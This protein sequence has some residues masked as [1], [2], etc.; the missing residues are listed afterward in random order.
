MQNSTDVRQPATY[1]RPS[2]RDELMAE[3]FACILSGRPF[4]E[5]LR[6]APVVLARPASV[7]EGCRRILAG[8]QAG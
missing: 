2:T 8:P 3:A 7:E 6:P 5:S 1:T 4:P